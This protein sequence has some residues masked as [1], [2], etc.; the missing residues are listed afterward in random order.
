MANNRFQLEIL[1][2]ALL[3]EITKY[4][5]P[6]EI[7]N[8]IMTCKTMLMAF[9]QLD[10]K[11]FVDKS[12]LNQNGIYDKIISPGIDFT[13]TRLHSFFNSRIYARQKNLMQAGLCILR[14]KMN[15]ALE[16]IDKDPDLLQQ[17][18]PSITLKKYPTHV[19]E[20]HEGRTLFQ[21]ALGT[22]D[23]ELYNA[24]GQRIE[25]KY[26]VAIKAK[27]FNDQFPNGLK[28]TKS[29]RAV[30]DSLIKTM[31]KDP[32]ID[33]V[34]DQN[35]MNDTT[36]KE[37]QAFQDSLTLKPID[38]FTT[39]VPLDLQIVIDFI[40]AYVD[41]YDEF[42]DENKKWDQRA[43]YWRCVFGLIESRAT[44]FVAMALNEKNNFF[45]VMEGRK[46]VTRDTSGVDGAEFFDLR[47]GLSHYKIAGWPGRSSLVLGGRGTW[48]VV[49]E[50]CLAR[51]KKLGDIRQQLQQPTNDH[52]HEINHH[53]GSGCQIV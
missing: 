52:L 20:K 23:E 50:F 15:E 17:V 6:A 40:D 33:L 1:P 9:K 44:Y 28:S 51:T 43:L 25:S 26:G 41:G 2:D 47:L 29:Y 42:K 30:F 53:R 3:L 35:I 45:E 49:K 12:F 19:G 48:A 36:R 37:L 31:A 34:N 4:L 38:K 21:L 32:T 16:I 13:D 27:Q 5:S 18:I 10:R 11:G 39:D 46:K 14:S 7:V 8:L 22:Y 24:I